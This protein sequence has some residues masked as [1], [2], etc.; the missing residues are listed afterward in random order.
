MINLRIITLSL[1][2]TFIICANLYAQYDNGTVIYNQTSSTNLTS[3]QKNYIVEDLDGDFNADVIMIKHNAT[4]NT[5][6]LTWYKG[7]AN[8]NFTPQPNIMSI[9]NTH[10]LNEIFYEDMNGDGNIAIQVL[11]FY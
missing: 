9:D 6:Q 10:R 1:I 2:S 8:G 3:I 4:N 7:N 11:Q 5:N